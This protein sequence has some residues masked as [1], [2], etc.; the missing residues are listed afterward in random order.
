MIVLRA[1][2][3]AATWLP[4]QGMVGASL[5]HQGGEL[6]GQRGGLDA[7]LAK[8]SAFGIPLLAPWANRLDGLRYGDVVIDPADAKLDGNALPKDGALAG[9]TWTVLS[10]EEGRLRAG[11]VADGPVLAVFPFPHAWSVDVTLDPEGMT[12]ATTLT[13][14]GEVLV[15]VSFGWHPL[16]TLPGV[17]RDDLHVTLPVRR[18]TVLDARGIPTGEELDAE[19]VD[20]MLPAATLDAEY[21]TWDGDV[22]LRGGGRELRVQFGGEDYPVGHAWAPEGESFVAWE[23]MTAP[24]NALVTGAGLRHVA[25]GDAFTA[26][27][28]VAVR[29]I[30]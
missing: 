23:P 21:T 10:A 29:R 18:Q 22:V 15:P 26:V 12:V 1:G 13:A 9:R 28:R 20:G 2:D 25:P 17:A 30:D 6:L 16:F 14:T 7:Y 11:F 5:T 4:E 3:L 27:F 24:T 19:A 8:G